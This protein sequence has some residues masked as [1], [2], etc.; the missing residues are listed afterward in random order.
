MSAAPA[1]V[2]ACLTGD[3][4]YDA[5]SIATLEA[6]VRKQ[7]AD[8]THN[9]DGSFALSQDTPSLATDVVL[10]AFQRI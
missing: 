8:S 7:V 5:A 6:Y 4:R 3:A 10:S 2:Q 9:I 1:E